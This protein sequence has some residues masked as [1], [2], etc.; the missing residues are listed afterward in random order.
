MGE[1]CWYNESRIL[2][3]ILYR[4]P[5]ITNFILNL[6]LWSSST[7]L[8]LY[9]SHLRM[10][11]AM[12][13]HGSPMSVHMQGCSYVFIPLY[14]IST[15]YMAPVHS[16]DNACVSYHC[17]HYSTWLVPLFHTIPHHYSAEVKFCHSTSTRHTLDSHLPWLDWITKCDLYFICLLLLWS[18]Y[19]PRPLP[20]NLRNVGFRIVILIRSPE[21]VTTSFTTRINHSMIRM[22]LACY[23]YSHLTDTSVW[24]GTF[25]FFS[26]SSE[27][28]VSEDIMRSVA[29]DENI[30]SRSRF[31]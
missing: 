9:D 20:T 18:C 26:S 12:F 31:F 2:F 6:A 30:L 15:I 21:S 1:S 19:F 8:T 28:L 17:H 22:I 25:L 13:G 4:I 29:F 7:Y 24:D 3:G 14:I 27:I 10:I 5:Q 23:V 16:R 11:T